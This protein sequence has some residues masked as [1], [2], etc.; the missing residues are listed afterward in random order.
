MFR[1]KTDKWYHV[2][3]NEQDIVCTAGHP[4]YVADLETFVTA[5]DL[6]VGQNVLLADGTCAT[7]EEIRVQKLRIPETTYNFEV[8]DFHTYYVSGDKVLVHNICSLDPKDI[9]Y[10][11]DSISPYFQDHRT[12]DD[13]IK[14]L[15]NGTISPDDVPAINVYK[16]NG[17]IYS[18]DNRRL[19]A[20]KKAGMSRINV[21]WVNTK[22]P[23][24]AKEIGDKF[25][26]ITQ[27][28]SIIVRGGK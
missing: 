1:N 2:H 12:V 11:Q 19:Y 9:R 20:F 24:V 10:T 15:K 18:L 25:T 16:K 27:G 17:I 21:K 23:K 28:L 4:F 7:I 26:T 8:E 3:V 5:K 6:K 14:G 13:L 22:D